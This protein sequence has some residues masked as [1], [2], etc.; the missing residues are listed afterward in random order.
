VDVVGGLA[1]ACLLLLLLLLL[2]VL[3]LVGVSL[4][5]VIVQR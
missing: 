4:M 3:V 2:R 1:P 5:R